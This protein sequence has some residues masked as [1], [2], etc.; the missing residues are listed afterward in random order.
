MF[1]LVGINNFRFRLY[2]KFLLHSQQLLTNGAMVGIMFVM[3]FLAQK[4]QRSNQSCDHSQ[5][6]NDREHQNTFSSQT[7]HFK[8]LFLRYL[9]SFSGA[10][11]TK[12]LEADLLALNNKALVRTLCHWK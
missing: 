12:A 3:V 2:R 6:A 11:R 8:P 9:N 4:V 10:G 5:E 7:M 1:E